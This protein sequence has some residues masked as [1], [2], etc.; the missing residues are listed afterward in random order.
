MSILGAL[1]FFFAAKKQAARPQTVAS[2]AAAQLTIPSL[3][4]SAISNPKRAIN[5]RISA[6]PASAKILIDGRELAGNPVNFAVAGDG[7]THSLSIQASEFK[8][9]T[10]NLVYDRE[11]DVVV[12]LEPNVAATSP[13]SKQLHQSRPSPASAA[14]GLQ[15]AKNECEPPYFVDERGIKHF[16]PGCI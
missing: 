10:L 16:K 4:G 3:E 6:S 15:S 12:A 1:L 13:S 5:L 9:R 11:Q 8:S 2:G 7:S 14:G